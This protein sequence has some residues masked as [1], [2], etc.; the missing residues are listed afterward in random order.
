MH[1]TGDSL[2][3]N[4]LISIVPGQSEAV[5]SNASEVAQGRITQNSQK[6]GSS[7]K[8]KTDQG[9]RK[10]SAKKLQD[11]NPDEKSGRRT[12]MKEQFEDYFNKELEKR[13]ASPDKRSNSSEDLK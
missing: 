11:G 8:R 3:G 2:L 6:I 1:S 7:D 9:I 5:G 13:G 4:R 10:N 12:N